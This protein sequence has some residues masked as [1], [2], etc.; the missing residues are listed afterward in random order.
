MPRKPAGL[1]S[2][3]MPFS[4]P[5]GALAR[6]S[7]RVSFFFAPASATA[8]VA[9]AASGLAAS[10]ALAASATGALAGAGAACWAT[11]TPSHRLKAKVARV[12][13]ITGRFFMGTVLL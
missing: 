12:K 8:A 7:S 2:S 3:I 13:A 1:V 9:L 5:R 10:T 11:A 4:V 6:A